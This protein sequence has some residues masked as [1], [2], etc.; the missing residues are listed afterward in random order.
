MTWIYDR[1]TQR[2]AA[3]RPLGKITKVEVK[4]YSPVL[5]DYNDFVALFDKLNHSRNTEITPTFL[6]L[7]AR[8]M[9]L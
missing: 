7:E 9:D 4:N 2:N 6:Y 8:L 3:Q 1:I 5:I